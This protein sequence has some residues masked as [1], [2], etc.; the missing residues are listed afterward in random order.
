MGSRS[1]SWLRTE[2]QQSHVAWGWCTVVSKPEAQYFVSI[3]SA[4]RKPLVLASPALGLLAH[5]YR[6]Q[7][8]AAKGCEGRH[9]G[10]RVCGLGLGCCLLPCCFWKESSWEIRSVMASLGTSGVLSVNGRDPS[11]RESGW[12]LTTWSTE[13]KGRT[14]CGFSGPGLRKLVASTSSL[15]AH[16]L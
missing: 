1:C 7:G 2:S 11:P 6:T 12:T 9:S 3:L 4:E 8:E 15:L 5:G 14:L 10:G 13:Y 16:S